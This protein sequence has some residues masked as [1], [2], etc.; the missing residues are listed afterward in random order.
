MRVPVLLLVLFLA[1]LSPVPAHEAVPGKADIALEEKLGSV[2][3]ADISLHDENGKPVNLKSF[4]DKPTI[5][6]PVYLHC[7]HECP[8]LLTGL[9]SALGKLELVLEPYQVIWIVPS[10]E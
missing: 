2:I 4:I 9:A 1:S 10:R 3:P 5:I 6:A 8:M 7:S